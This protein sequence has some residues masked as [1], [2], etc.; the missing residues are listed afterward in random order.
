MFDETRLNYVVP[1]HSTESCLL[2]DKEYGDL[3]EAILKRAIEDYKA[4]LGI[5][6]TEVIYWLSKPKR[7]E[8]EEFF[9]SE[10]FTWLSG[11]N[12]EWFIRQFRKEQERLNVKQV[13]GN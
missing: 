2:H 12:G 3:V 11:W 6:Y 8:L 9:R 10:W 4:A 1:S 7:E 13:D 5:S